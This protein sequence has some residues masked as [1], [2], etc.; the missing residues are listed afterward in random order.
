[1]FLCLQKNESISRGIITAGYF[2]DAG[3]NGEMGGRT[4]QGG[5]GGDR[6]LRSTHG[7]AVE[8]V[9][10]RQEPEQAAAGQFTREFAILDLKFDK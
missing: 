7:E 10:K 5:E 9:G 8:G 1:M 3:Q 6:R 4:S 2:V